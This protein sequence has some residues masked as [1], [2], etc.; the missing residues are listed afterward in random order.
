MHCFI[1]INIWFTLENF[2]IIQS[3]FQFWSLNNYMYR[4]L[5]NFKF[6]YNTLSYL[7][8]SFSIFLFFCHSDNFPYKSLS[9]NYYRKFRNKITSK[10][11][12]V[13]QPNSHLLIHFNCIHLLHYYFIFFLH[14]CN[15]TVWLFFKFY[16]PNSNF[17]S[18]LIFPCL[19]Q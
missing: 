18:I 3:I 16:L 17:S 12:H 6:I 7:R 15:I 4:F 2:Q 11:F 9:N 19:G 5:Y 14:N 13:N 1:K 8:K 10:N